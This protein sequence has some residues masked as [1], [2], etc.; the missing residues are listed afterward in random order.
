[1]CGI[2]GEYIVKGRLTDETTFCKLNDLAITRGPDHAG[3]WTDDMHCRLGFRRLS[4][5]DLSENGNQP[6]ISPSGRWVMIFNGEIYNFA[7][8]KKQIPEGVY[9][10]RGHSDSEVILNAFEYFGVEKTVHMLD[11]MFGIALYDREK[12]E[13]HLVRDFA[14]IKPLFYGFDGNHLVFGSQYNQV[15]GHP[16]Y[17]K[18]SIDAAGLKKYL[19]QHYMPAPSAVVNNTYQLH[20]GEMITFSSTG[21][22]SKVRYWT[23][24][25]PEIKYRS[26]AEAIVYLDEK[27]RKAVKDE[28]VADV[29]VGTFL[30]G[31]IDSPLITYYTKQLT[32]GPLKAFSIGSDSK[33]HDESEDALEYGRQIGVE[34]Y[35][36]MMDSTE[37]RAIMD[38]VIKAMKEPFADFSIIPTWLVSKLAKERVTVA[39]SGDGGD[40]LFYGYERFWSL[41]KNLKFRF[42]P[43]PLRYAAY[44]ADKVLFQNRNINSNFLH[45]DIGQAHKS[46]HSSFP[47]SLISDLFPDLAGIDY[48]IDSFYQYPDKTDEK[49]LLPYMQRAE[50]YDMMQKTLRKVDQASMA[51]SLEVRVPFLKKSFIEAS[52]QID[53]YL[54][55]SPVWKK[56]IL[57]KLLKKKLPNAPIT[58]VK[59]GFTIPLAKWIKEDLRRPFEEVL[60]DP[61]FLT[62]FSLSEEKLKRLMHEHV[63]GVRNHKWPIFTLY[64]LSCWNARRQ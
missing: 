46:L 51:V 31:G 62:A 44:G 56:E 7:E 12:K 32:D 64:A 63:S 37:A 4:I 42:I 20:P 9:S 60:F 11:G 26:E 8:I 30:S 17:K 35:L 40:E 43:R 49:Q 18:E 15:I 25:A 54:S 2:F 57:K 61:S 6:M 5:L 34:S 33:V 13:I 39:L 28:L 22:V 16:R 36:S 38:E 48:P 10:Y 1:M 50:F 55:F 29:P 45:R 47:S 41:S 59:K 53:P 23:M 24:P 52:L 14:G 58:N 3:Y 27:L 19:S 21:K